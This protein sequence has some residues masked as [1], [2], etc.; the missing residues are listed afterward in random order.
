M[1]QI[2]AGRKNSHTHSLENYPSNHFGHGSDHNSDAHP[3]STC[4]IPIVRAPIRK[5]Q[6]THPGA[7]DVVLQP[8]VLEVCRQPEVDELNV[9]A[10]LG[11]VCQDV[12]Q[13]QVAMLNTDN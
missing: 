13:L 10:L 12:V 1:R 7:D 9:C 11:L 2:A 4:D 5:G 6:P 8:E 3:P